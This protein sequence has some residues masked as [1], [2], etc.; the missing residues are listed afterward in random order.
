MMNLSYSPLRSKLSR[1][2]WIKNAFLRFWRCEQCARLLHEYFG[3]DY[4]P[5]SDAATAEAPS[6]CGQHMQL[7]HP[8]T[9]N[10]AAEALDIHYEIIGGLNNNAV[11]VHWSLLATHRPRWIALQT[12]TGVY[13]KHIGLA[14]LPPVIFPLSD[15][16]AYA[17]CDKAICEQCY[18]CCKKGCIIYI[19]TDVGALLSIKMDKISKY[20][21]KI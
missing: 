7:L 4:A 8:E 11:K 6:C 1:K 20:F 16:D 21:M 19:Y 12:Y 17:Y 2:P 3:E 13:L 15:E 5:A 18:Y 9:T 14:K 10:N